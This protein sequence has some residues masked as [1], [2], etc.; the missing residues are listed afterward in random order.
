[1]QVTLS[2]EKTKE[3]LTEVTVRN[4]AYILKELKESLQRR[5]G[6]DIKEVILFGS[7]ASGAAHSD[8]DYDILIVLSR[9]YDREFRD[10][11]TDIVYNMELK[12]SILI[13]AHLISVS[14]LKDSLRGA[15]PV[16]ADAVKHGIYAPNEP[17]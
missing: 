3:L 13:D 16:F 14:E 1:M 2:D 12:H 7:Q 5:F 10:S 15:Q 6:N 9:Q 17:G 11:I 8:S 4:K